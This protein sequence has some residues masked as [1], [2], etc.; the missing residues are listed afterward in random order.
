MHSLRRGLAQRLIVLLLAVAM[1]LCCCVVKGVAAVPS[2]D[3]PASVVAT[4]C[5]DT[6]RSCEEP[7]QSS[8][9]DSCRA[10]CCVK[11]PATIDDWTPPSDVIGQALPPVAE[12][13]AMASGHVDHV[14][15]GGT[16]ATAA[17][18]PGPWGVSAPPLRHATILQV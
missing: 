18:P 16:N 14:L 10:C 6:A 2:S 15:I 5:C 8:E 3:S 7:Q 1:P 11:A 13:E 4:C 12:H 17:S 9:P